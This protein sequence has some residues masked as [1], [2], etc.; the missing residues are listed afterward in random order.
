LVYHHPHQR[1]DSYQ[2][3]WAHFVACVHSSRSPLVSGEDGYAVLK[4]ITAARSALPP[5][6]LAS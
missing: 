3:Q 4:M 2:A 5:S 6:A 1:D